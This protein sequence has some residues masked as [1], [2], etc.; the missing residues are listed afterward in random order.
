SKGM[1]IEDC[2]FVQYQYLLRIPKTKK[3][4]N[5]GKIKLIGYLKKYA[6]DKELERMSKAEWKWNCI[7][8][9]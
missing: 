8:Q 4:M 7:K 6:V 1:N 9:E 5:M 3:M 2:G